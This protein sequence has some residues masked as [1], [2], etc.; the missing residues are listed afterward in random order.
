M[1]PKT[2]PLYSDCNSGYQV[3]SR[4]PFVTEAVVCYQGRYYVWHGELAWG[5]QGRPEEAGYIEEEV[6]Q[7]DGVSSPNA[8]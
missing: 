8:S 6:F 1:E 3:V 7:W 2:Y 4:V 5:R